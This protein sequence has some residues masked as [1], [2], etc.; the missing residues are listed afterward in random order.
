MDLFDALRILRRRWLLVVPLVVAVVGLTAFVYLGST[1]VYTSQVSIGITSA[2]TTSTPVTADGQAKLNQS[3]GLI[4]SGGTVLVANLLSIALDDAAV[5]DALEGQGGASYTTKVLLQGNNSQ[6]PIVQV[7][8]IG[9]TSATVSATL[10]LTTERAV[11]ELST[12]QTNAGVPD[13]YAASSFQV[14]GAFTPAASNPGRVRAAAATAV[15]GL[16]LAMV[17]TVVVDSALTRRAS[18][19]RGDDPPPRGGNGRASHR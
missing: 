2:S 7:T 4:T 1:T 5:Q 9:P 3:N 16:G 6:L 8:A 11:T 15:A 19:R 13:D 10:A 18:R 17:V 14:E 12:I